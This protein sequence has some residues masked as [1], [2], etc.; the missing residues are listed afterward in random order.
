MDEVAKKKY[1]RTHKHS[2]CCERANK[3]SEREHVT[4]AAITKR[5]DTCHRRPTGRDDTIQKMSNSITFHAIMHSDAP[6]N[7]MH[8][9]FNG[10]LLCK[11]INKITELNVSS[12]HTLRI[13]CPMLR[14]I[15]C[16]IVGAVVGRFIRC[17]AGFG[18][19]I[20]ECSNGCSDTNVKHFLCDNHQSIESGADNR[21]SQSFVSH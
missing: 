16:S 19:H 14:Y 6:G 1:A 21:S 2:S 13:G 3:Q 20:N 11:L 8:I 5:A 7:T 18:G 9:Y 10:E 12:L 15:M 17:A 4:N